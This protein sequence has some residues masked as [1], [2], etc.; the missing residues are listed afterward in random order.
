M[1]AG[2]MAVKLIALLTSAIDIDIQVTF[3]TRPIYTGK[4]PPVPNEYEAGLAH[5]TIWTTRRS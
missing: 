2:G 3:A 1:W 4:E 5:E